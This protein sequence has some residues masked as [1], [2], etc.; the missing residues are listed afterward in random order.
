MGVNLQP[1]STNKQNYYRLVYSSLSLPSL[2]LSLP[3]VSVC[4]SLPPSP[5]CFGLSLCLCLSVPLCLSMSLSLSVCLPVS[6]SVCLSVCLS[7]SFSLSVCLSVS[8]SLCLSL[9]LSVCLFAS[10]SVCL[11]LFL[12][13][14]TCLCLSACLSV[15]PSVCLSVSLLYALSSRC[16]GNQRRVICLDVTALTSLAYLGSMSSSQ[17][18]GDFFWLYV[19]LSL[20]CFR[21]LLPLVPRGQSQAKSRGSNDHS[22]QCLWSKLQIA[23]VSPLG[24]FCCGLSAPG[25]SELCDW[26]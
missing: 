1:L 12:S 21:N 13:V 17:A 10:A 25:R 24:H 22:L 15:S 7:L 20:H 5:P 16:T 2:S 4:L 14:S 11:S 9:S 26:I 8:L 3:S 23:P 19:V 6:L 18:H